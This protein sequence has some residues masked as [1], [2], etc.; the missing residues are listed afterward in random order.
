MSNS[1]S[2][3]E[4][5]KL[6]G[7]SPRRLRHLEEYGYIAPGWQEV[8]GGRR[9]RVYDEATIQRLKAMADLIRQGFPPRVAAEKATPGGGSR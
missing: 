3:S 9:I 4:A 6:S 8:G 5:A 2:I 7:L 1:I